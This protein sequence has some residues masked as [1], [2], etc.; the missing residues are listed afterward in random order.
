V[1][2]YTTDPLADP[3]WDEL[4]ESHPRAS[5]FHHRGWISALASTY[6][7]EPLALTSCAPDT[8]LKDAVVL[9]GI[10]SWITGKRL[11]SLP[12]ADHCDLLLKKPEDVHS[13]SQWLQ[14]ECGRRRCRYIELRPRTQLDEHGFASGRSYYFHV[15]DLTP[16]LGKLFGALHKNSSQRKIR[17]AEKEGIRYEVG[18]SSWH[19]DELYRLMVM[20]RRRH[21]LFPQPLSWFQNLVAGM[22]DKVQVWLAFK[23]QATVAAMLTLRHRSSVIY[24]YGCSDEKFHRLGVMPFLFW[25]LIEES[26]T[27]GGREIDFGRSDTDNE[28]LATF[29]DHFGARRQRLVYYNYSGCDQSMRENHKEWEIFRPLLPILPDV[30]LSTGGRLLYRHMG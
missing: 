1:K 23:D 9:C 2:I 3:R 16:S 25:K 17:R 15:L 8:P 14:D 18:R 10:S 13:F 20:T 30:L 29:K 11:V 21:R 7:Y 28:G 24:K 27:S 5:A 12:F 22:G 6:G 19:L 26:K 4:V